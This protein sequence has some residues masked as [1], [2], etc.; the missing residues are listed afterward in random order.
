MA[1]IY[2]IEKELRTLELTRSTSDYEIE[3]ELRTLELT[4]STSDLEFDK[5]LRELE[6]KQKDSDIKDQIFWRNWNPINQ[7]Q[8]L[9]RRNM[10]VLI[11]VI[12]LAPASY[13]TDLA[14]KKLE[15]L[16]NNINAPKLSD[17]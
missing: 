10:E 6:L 15:E 13:I 4:R 9:I 3:K 17:F 14:R 11:N 8:E 5:H 12:K 2:E 16:I 1:T 7:Q